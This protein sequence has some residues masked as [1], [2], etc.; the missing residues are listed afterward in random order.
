MRKYMNDMLLFHTR[1]KALTIA[2]GVIALATTLTFL[3]RLPFVTGSL[4]ILLVLLAAFQFGQTGGVIAALWSILMI[5][6]VYA[7]PLYLSL[8][9]YITG[10][11]GYFIFGWCWAGPLI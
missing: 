5:T 9:G 2:I 11:A 8:T 4:G 10:S 1:P 7:S 6:F 3:H